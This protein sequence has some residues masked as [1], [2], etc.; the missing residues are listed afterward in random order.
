MKRIFLVCMLLLAMMATACS[1]NPRYSRSGGTAFAQDEDGRKDL[2]RM[3]PQATTHPAVE[4]INLIELL[5]PDGVV[6]G[7]NFASGAQAW[8]ELSYSARY[9]ILFA[10]FRD[11]HGGGDGAP[12]ALR[13]KRN[14]IQNTL[15]MASERRCGRYFTYLKTESADNNFY[16][17][18]ATTLFSALGSLVPG[19]RAGHN[20]SGVGAVLSGVRAEYNN[21]Y[22]SNLAVSVI[23]RAIE[24]K[25]KT[26]REQMQTR[27]RGDYD[28][29]DVAAAVTDAVGYD[30]SCSIVNGLEQAN[31]AVQRLNEP[32]RDAVNRALLKDRIGRAIASDDPKALEALA[33]FFDE[34]G[35]KAMPAWS[36][37]LGSPAAPP[38]AAQAGEGAPSASPVKLAS[39]SVARIRRS[40]DGLDRDLRQAVTDLAQPKGSTTVAALQ[41]SITAVVS[42]LGATVTGSLSGSASASCVVEASA[43]ATAL[44]SAEAAYY[45]AKA[46]GE[47]LTPAQDSLNDTRKSLGSFQDKLRR[48]EASVSNFAR[49]S[50]AA[51]SAALK[52]DPS[53]LDAAWAALRPRLV[54]AKALAEVT[55]ARACGG[56]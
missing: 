24:E 54:P 4:T 41:A 56:R 35:N 31:E 7:R 42:Q 26:L 15:L 9:D 44:G 30:A 21:E 1:T 45:Q 40:L 25:R 18:A 47:S 16:F 37:V 10:K 6:A 50:L 53:D 33:G 28:G 20:L 51:F 8:K 34:L 14:L 38:V 46:R 22:Y 39:E 2:D 48:H 23:T 13:Q 36:G 27:Q 55:P 52:G 3:G 5:D 19:V 49:A 32:G 12:D 17:G 29:Y 11:I 43:L